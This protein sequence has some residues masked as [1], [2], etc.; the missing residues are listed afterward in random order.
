MCSS[1][2]QLA[3]ASSDLSQAEKKLNIMKSWANSQTVCTQND[4]FVHP[5]QFWVLSF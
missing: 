2:L 4:N 3:P 1:L 5:G